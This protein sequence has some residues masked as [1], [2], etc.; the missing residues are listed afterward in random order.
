MPTG[1]GTRALSSV[2]V[3]L[4]ASAVVYGPAWLLTLILLALGFIGV[5]EMYTLLGGKGVSLPLPLGLVLVSVLVLSAASSSLNLLDAAVF[6]AG[7][8]P[9]VWAMRMGPRTGGLQ[10]WAF[11]AVGALYV[12]WP[13]AHIEL[14]R[15]LP[16]GQG[17]LVFAVACTWATDTGAYLCGSLFGRTKLAPSISPGKTIEG[18]LGAFALTGLVGLL[19][20]ALVGLDIGPT[21]IVLISLLLSVVTQLGDLAESYI[22]R[23]AG[24]KDSGHLLPGHG[25]LLDRIDGLLWTVVAAYYLAL[26]IS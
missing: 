19:V 22:K 18:S 20:A 17:W 7:A 16:D 6:L 25:G 15:Q 4:V 2:L 13:L 23:V 14:L 5:S 9:L 1:L 21:L 10:V 11:S 8:L 12:G 26:A 24:A 3:V